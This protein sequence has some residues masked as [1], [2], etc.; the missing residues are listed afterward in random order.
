M[1]LINNT[2]VFTINEC[3]WNDSYNM[4]QF[5]EY[6]LMVLVS[7]DRHQAV[8]AEVGEGEKDRK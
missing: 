1:Y 4:I 7:R 6:Q 8:E 5:R 3:F 2:R